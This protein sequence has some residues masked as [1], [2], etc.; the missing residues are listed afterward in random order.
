MI[1]F[2]NLVIVFLF[3][4]RQHLTQEKEEKE[5]ENFVCHWN[6]LLCKISQSKKKINKTR[7]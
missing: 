4:F 3:I 6:G 2:S 1:I 5:A 7:D